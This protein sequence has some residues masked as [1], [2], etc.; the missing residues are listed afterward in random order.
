MEKQAIQLTFILIPYLADPAAGTVCLPGYDLHP[1]LARTGG[2]ARTR[3]HTLDVPGQ[4][5]IYK[6]K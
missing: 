6:Y 1:H 3:D 5:E 4:G 2:G